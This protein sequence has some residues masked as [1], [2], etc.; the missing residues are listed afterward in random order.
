M[1]DPYTAPRAAS[2]ALLLIDVQRDF[3][4]AGAPARIAG[5]EELLGAM[6]EVA[7]AF[8][9]AGRPVLHVIRLY[10]PDGSNVD[11]VRRGVVEGGA[12]IVAPGT[13]GSQIAPELLPAPAE[14]DHELLLGGGF[15]QLG[16]GEYAVYKPRWGA[17]YG[18]TVEEHLRAQ[19]V[20]TVVFAG[21]NFPNCPRTSVYEA[22]ER[23]FRVVLVTDAM[24]GVY[25]RGL[26]ECRNIGVRTWDLAETRD[27][28][29]SA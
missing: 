26:A 24:S 9:A 28:L 18:T 8:R 25:E 7:A 16:P 27:W 1:A 2:S 14:V 4:E 15:Q 20:D 12:S 13:A 5:T 11:V 17:F 23:D 19:G 29:A 6:A 3:Y 21:C 22:S 10:R